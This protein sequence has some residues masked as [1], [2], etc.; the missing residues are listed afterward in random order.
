LFLIP[1]DGGPPR[2]LAKGFTTNPVWSPSEDLIVYAGLES[3]AASP[4]VAIR[5]DGSAFDL[6]AIKVQPFGE[7]IRFLPDGKSLIYMQGS[8]TAQDF[9]LLDLTTKVP[10]RL[11]QFSD[12]ATM[13]TFDVPDG[14]RIV[15]DRVHENSN[16][17]LI[18]LPKKP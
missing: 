18:D 3:A 15:F 17:Q 9:W 12:P 6:P 4:L 2:P 7:R 1:T 14:K 11:T 8:L 10:R 5:L 13:R 16:I